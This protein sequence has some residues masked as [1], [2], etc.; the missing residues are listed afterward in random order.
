MNFVSSD[1]HS[2]SNDFW[3]G[4]YA[5]TWTRV[6]D[7]DRDGK[8]VLEEVAAGLRS[9]NSYAVHGDLIDQLDF[10]ATSA[11][12][13]ATMGETLRVKHEGPMSLN[14]SF[15]LPETNYNGDAPKVRLI[16]VIAGEVHDPA[17]KFLAD[18]TTPNPAYEK[19]TN[20]TARI[21]AVFRENELEYEGAGWYRA[22]D[23]K[24]ASVDKDM[25]YRIRG[26]NLPPDTPNETDA[27]GSPL[28]DATAREDLNA[29]R[30][31]AAWQDLWFYSNP[32]FV[33]SVD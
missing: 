17:P 25:Y 31:E 11:I 18:G 14:I 19:E 26:T 10:S 3:P 22:P 2:P 9:G 13:S 5:K 20:E 28:A 29:G 15:R 30:V 7:L 21:V 1:F 6:Q 23:F 32:I 8:Y 33:Q 27:E 12:G 24:V 16:Q 4:E